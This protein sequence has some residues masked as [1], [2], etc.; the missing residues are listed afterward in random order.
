MVLAFRRLHP[1]L[2][3]AGGASRQGHRCGALPVAA[4]VAWDGN[5]SG[6]MWG[7]GLKGAIDP[8]RQVS[9]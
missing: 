6:A 3:R 9:G 8:V 5:G 2:R 4:T 7:A 1:A